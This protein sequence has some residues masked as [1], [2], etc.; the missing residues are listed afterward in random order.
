MSDH[1]IDA[2]QL[3]T[4]AN[5][6]S[7]YPNTM[8]RTA[9]TWTLAAVF[10]GTLPQVVYSQQQQT[11]QQQQRQQETQQLLRQVQ[12]HLDMS[13]FINQAGYLPTAEKYCV[14]VPGVTEFE[15][16]NVETNKAV[17]T[18]KLEPGGK[19]F[20]EYVVGTFT[21]VQIPG[22]YYIR[23]G[24]ARSYP[25]KISQSV[26][27]EPMQLIV[28]YFSKQRCGNSTT[29][30]LTPCHLEDGLRKENG[31]YRDVS[32][33]W[34][35]A[36]DLRKWV[37][38]TIYGM[39]GMLKLLETAKPD[40]EK[41]Q[42][43]EELRWGNRYFLNMQE[44]DGFVMAHAGGDLYQHSDNNRWTDNIMGNN[45]DRWIETR[46]LDTGGQYTF[47]AV[48]AMMAR[49]TRDDA[50]Y[51]RRCLDAAVK[52]FDWCE[53]RT[54]NASSAIAGV[55]I[56]A[57]VE[58]YKTTGESKYID[59]AYQNADR[60]VARQIPARSDSPVSG[61][62][63]DAD[64]SENFYKDI[65]RMDCVIIGLCHLVLAF[66]ERQNEKYIEAI[67]GYCEDYLLVISDR[68]AFGL[69][70]YEVY[71]R[72]TPGSRELGGGYSYKYF[73]N[74]S[75]SWW[76]GINANITGKGL[77]LAM[78]SRILDDPKY[79]AVAQRQ[80]D[81]VL[82]ANPFGTSTMRGI[83]FEHPKFETAYIGGFGP[84]VTPHIPGA[85]LNGIGGDADDMPDLKPGSWQ[86]CEY[87][88][89]MI[90]LTLWLMAE[91]S[92]RQ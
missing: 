66:P 6:H 89:P 50:E 1:L 70:P 46:P 84:P 41:G 74:P 7:I 5:K 86:T 45:D 30:Y 9:L 55:A 58:L 59:F 48:Q 71:A 2:R 33:G 62:F 11:P 4:I 90:G 67:R 16:L 82:G 43:M 40:W 36:S 26:Y 34:H 54:R 14:T 15:V 35:D 19:D 78:A 27:E 65:G 22:T 64:R 57:A 75:L 77:G 12:R 10:F 49:F 85:V 73:M 56:L 47:V 51:S 28:Y 69:L 53:G 23:A 72:E 88:T 68:N 79:A 32:G 87:W 91:L 20:G 37:G 25:F 42:V 83:G 29:G 92:E 3:V 18:G 24:K 21:P 60:I 39:V 63:R 38:A 17:Y 76:V 31:E 81:W 13:V 61:F 8:M 80:L 52:C 44:P